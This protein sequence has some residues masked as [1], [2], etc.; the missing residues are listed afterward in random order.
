MRGLILGTGP[1]LS[2]VAHLIPKFDGLVFGC[3]NTFQDFKLSVHLSCDPK[4]H[5]R[6]SPI[7]PVWGDFE[8][9]H[10]DKGICE[11]YGYRY[12][13]GVWLDG[14]YMGPE[15]KISLGHCSGHQ[16]LN[17]AAGNQYGC[18]EIILVGHDFRYEPGKPRHYFTG[19]SDVD[20][21][22]VPELRKFSL[23]DK[24]GQG[25]DLMK[26]YQHIADQKGLPPII[27]CTPGSH[28]KCFPMG[29][30]EDYLEG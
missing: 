18:D 30:L 26:V 11:K 13:E 23:F 7:P 10:W 25:N 9:W 17:L 20:G 4:W 27:N 28:L 5:D 14:L 15:N 24:Q 2:D 1:S 6:Y 21:E 12:V 3:N 29:N 16:L 22:Y 19:L 8:C